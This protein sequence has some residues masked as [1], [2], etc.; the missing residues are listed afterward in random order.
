MLIR[1]MLLKY[2]YQDEAGGEDKA[3]G[4]AP[5]AEVD[6]P[7]PKPST[8]DKPAAPSK[9][10]AP[11][12][13][14]WDS[15]VSQ[16][17]EGK[18]ALA[19]AL[20]FLGTA[21]ID[22]AGQAF[23]LAKGG[24]FSLLAA[25]LAGKGLAGTDHMLDILKAEVAANDQ[26]A[27]DHA[28]ATEATLDSILGEEKDVILEWARSS[29]S[30]EEKSAINEML[31]AG[32]HFAHCAAVAMKVAFGQGETTKAAANPVE[33]SDGPSSGAK[34]MTAREFS[35]ECLKLSKANNGADPR[36]LPGYRSL[37]LRREVGRKQGI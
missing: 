17:A 24:D 8:E 36:S 3:A 33:H 22:P 5:A 9:T 27:K 2:V 21:G 16:Y 19:V 31:E 12:G 14:G 26:A 7:E 35:D 29:A 34:P 32:G 25:E 30:E 37:Q 6:T 15:V 23:E 20:G 11:A 18:P 1:N 10:E 28:A 13:G 4:G